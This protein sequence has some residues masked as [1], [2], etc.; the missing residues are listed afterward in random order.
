[1]ING[2]SSASAISLIVF[3]SS[4]FTIITA[5][6]P[7][8][9]A[10]MTLIPKLQPPPRRMATA[11]PLMRTLLWLVLVLVVVVVVV[12]VGGLMVGWLLVG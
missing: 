9:C 10:L 5:T 3:L 12:V 4:V 2:A 11:A 6:A 1:M 8:F 7:S